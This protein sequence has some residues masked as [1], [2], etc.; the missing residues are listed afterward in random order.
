[1]VAVRVGPIPRAGTPVG[2]HSRAPLS[3]AVAEYLPVPRPS[4]TPSLF[5]DPLALEVRTP[6]RGTGYVAQVWCVS[7]YWQLA[8]T[9]PTIPEARAAGARF[10]QSDPGP[11]P[12]H[13]PPGATWHK[14]R[15][16][17]H[18]SGYHYVRR[19]K[20]GAWQA[21][22][23]LGK[24][25]GSL[26]LGLFTKSEHGVWAERAAGLVAQAFVREW[27]PGRTVGAV[28]EALKR[29][30]REQ[31]RVPEAVVVPPHLW[32]LTPRRGGA[33]ETVEELVARLTAR[34]VARV[35]RVEARYPADLFGAS[36]GERIA[37]A[38]ARLE[39][40]HRARWDALDECDELC[41]A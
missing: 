14:R 20:G 12:G 39:R 22:A 1:M 5:P 8:G 34:G 32:P 6:K 40:M 25:G 41:A 3:P 16:R 33:E 7:G 17:R 13:E 38:R 11:E 30:P 37:E 26:N 15:E 9:F 10:A 4:A 19:V 23:W 29:A 28:V 24:G 18:R 2:K 31:D 21:R 27:R 35:A 36:A